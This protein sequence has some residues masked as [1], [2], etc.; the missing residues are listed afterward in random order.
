MSESL[1]PSLV[2]E[3]ALPATSGARPGVREIL[4]VELDK[5]VSQRPAQVVAAVCVLGPVAFAIVARA[6]SAVPADTL[7][8]RW[9]H[10]SGFALPLVVLG[11][12]G[13]WGFPVLAGLVGGDMF[14]GEDRH[15]TWKTVLTR[16]CDRRTL[17]AGKTLAASGYA[18]LMLAVLA[19]SSVAAGT[20]LVGTQQLVGLSGTLLPSGRSLALVLLGWAVVLLPVLGFV[21]LALLL[22]VTTRSSV[23]GVLG[24]V[25]V[26][27]VMQLVSLVGT[28]EIVRTLLLTSLFDAW[29]G[30]FVAH[31]HYGAIE[32]GSVVAVA[33]IAVCL[34]LA[35]HVLRRRD[36]A[37]DE[38]DGRA[39]WVVPAV[40]VA[41][42]AVVIAGLAVA[43]NLGPAAVTAS[44][45]DASLATTF[46]NLTAYQQ[47]LLGR[48][49]PAGATLHVLPSCARRGVSTPH[50]G[51]GDDW[52]C[53]LSVIGPGAQQMPVGYDVNVRPNGCYTAE[54]PP[55]FIGPATIRRPG[56]G[57]AANPLFVFDGCFDAG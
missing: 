48:H 32:R 7:F 6:Q 30:L 37:G 25:V 52:H 54:G 43:S 35:W 2:A 42:S 40:A 17:F 14:A 29:H 49:V 51:Q 18:V 22:S 15:G 24:P 33:Y 46:S 21:S 11:F 36:F 20:L 45:L 3:R 38:T 44:R 50:E 8:G 26:G 12:A 5:L 41:T 10:T 31:P 39:G 56:G 28:G 4:G 27:A 55:S 57:V 19:L 23:I 13:A 1:T 47:T 16:S 9:I 34:F 53:L